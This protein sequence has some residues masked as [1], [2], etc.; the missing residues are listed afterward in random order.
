[1]KIMIVDDEYLV[2]L[3]LRKTIDWE[4]YGY[5]IVGEAE[6]GRAG[7]ELA[8]KIRPNLIITDICMPFLDGIQ[9][10]EQLRKHELESK[11]IVLSGY[12]E[13]D[14]AQGAI[15]YGASDYILKPVENDKLLAAVHKQADI[16]RKETLSQQIVKQVMIADLLT[17]L[18]KI[19]AQKTT[20]TTKIVDQAIK[21]IKNHY[22][23]ELS[24]SIIASNLFFSPSYF[25][26][27]FKEN[28]NMTVNDFITEYRIAKAK[29]LLQ[30]NHYKVYEIC[31]QV[32]FQD[33]R[34]FSQIFK[35]STGMTPR[36][37]MNSTVYEK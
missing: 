26:H 1:M 35:K 15:T 33:P 4:Q 12:S 31:Q 19:R 6:D 36:E 28:M 30:S 24:I 23:E 10:M 17:Q 3:G 16:I 25:M 34:Y 2:R 5:E 32:G 27:V 22:A 11:I 18:R 20:G 14:Y 7:L 21:Y 29:E 9:F 8:L 13:F 37:Y